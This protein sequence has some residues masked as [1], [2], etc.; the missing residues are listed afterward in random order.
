MKDFV[1]DTHAIIWFLARSKKLSPKVRAIF[2]Q[3]KAGQG[4][5]IVPTMVLAEAIF[6]AQRQ[7]IDPPVIKVLLGL[8]ENPQ[9]GIYLYPLNKEVITAFSRFGSNAVPE[10]ADRIIAATALHLD[11]PLLTVDSSIEA[12]TLV[13]TIW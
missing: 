10:L 12:S 8:S 6:L 3:A 5:V 2:Q 13:K 9:D 7:R 11:L 1:A 4:H